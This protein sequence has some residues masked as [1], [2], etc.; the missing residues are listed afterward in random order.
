MT[1]LLSRSP[2]PVATR[3]QERRFGSLG[4]LKMGDD[5]YPELGD[6]VAASEDNSSGMLRS[7]SARVFSRIWDRVEYLLL[8]R[9]R[10][11]GPAER[12][13]MGSLGSST[14][15]LPLPRRHLLGFVGPDDGFDTRHE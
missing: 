12:G 8:E 2:N 3:F 10:R 7:E 5:L 13:R 6:L 11:H 4:P 14:R 9:P 1:A 15:V